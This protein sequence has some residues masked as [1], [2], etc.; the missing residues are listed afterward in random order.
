MKNN[1]KNKFVS[2]IPALLCIL[3]AAFFAAGAVQFMTYNRQILVGDR[4]EKVLDRLTAAEH[5]NRLIQQ[6][7]TGHADEARQALVLSLTHNL[8]SEDAAPVATD[9]SVG[10]FAK[11]VEVHIARQKKANPEAYQIQGGSMP[12][13]TAPTVGQMSSAKPVM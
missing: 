4:N 11:G 10:E 3:A 5:A 12:S 2:K 13:A 6:I 8:S 7:Q 9:G 1:M